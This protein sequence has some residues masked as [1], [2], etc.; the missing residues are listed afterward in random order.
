MSVDELLNSWIVPL[1]IRFD[2]LTV[3]S[4]KKVQVPFDPPVISTPSRSSEKKNTWISL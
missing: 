3:C 4:G 1:E 2:Y